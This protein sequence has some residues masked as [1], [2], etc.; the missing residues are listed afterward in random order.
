MVR[1][2]KDPHDRIFLYTSASLPIC[3]CTIVLHPNQFNLF[4]SHTF[5]QVS[6]LF[7]T[8][9][10]AQHSWPLLNLHYNPHQDPM[11]ILQAFKIDL[12]VPFF[13]EI[14]I[15]WSWSLWTARNDFIFKQQQPSLNVVKANFKHEL[16]LVVHRAKPAYKQLIST[17]LDN[18]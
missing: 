5:L 13:M 12:L 17:W 6:H 4:P 8:C 16:S 10:F 18:F 3:T 11:Q 1:I 14:I 7:L 9:T 2:G 15:L